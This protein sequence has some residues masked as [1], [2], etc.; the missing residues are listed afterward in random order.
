MKNRGAVVKAAHRIVDE[1]NLEFVIIPHAAR[2]GY[3]CRVVGPHNE[4]VNL[5]APRVDR[6]RSG[7]VRAHCPQLVAPNWSLWSSASQAQPVCMV[8]RG[9]TASS[10]ID[11]KARSPHQRRRHH[12]WVALQVSVTVPP[13]QE[14]TGGGIHEMAKVAEVLVTAATLHEKD[15]QP[16]APKAASSMAHTCEVNCE[17]EVPGTSVKPNVPWVETP[18]AVAQNPVSGS[19]HVVAET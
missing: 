10:K 19:Q 15:T 16:A 3:S 4:D 8:R 17:S 2:D 12:C 5:A 13:V 18:G 9:N 11:M 7:W 14:G 6:Y 1:S